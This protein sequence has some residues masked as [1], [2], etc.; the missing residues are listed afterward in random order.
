MH[1]EFV[2]LESMRTSNNVDAQDDYGL[3]MNGLE[4]MRVQVET[5]PVAPELGERIEIVDRD[6]LPMVN[7]LNLREWVIT[8][9]GLEGAADELVSMKIELLKKEKTEIRKMARD[10]IHCFMLEA[11]RAKGILNIKTMGDIKKYWMEQ[12]T[13]EKGIETMK[14]VLYGYYDTKKKWDELLEKKILELKKKKYRDVEGQRPPKGCIARVISEE[15]SEK[16]KQIQRPCLKEIRLGIKRENGLP[17]NVKKKRRKKETVYVSINNSTITNVASNN[18]IVSGM[19]TVDSTLI[20]RLRSAAS[21]AQGISQSD[22][23]IL[24]ASLIPTATGV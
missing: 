24:L 5:M 2:G 9:Y 11:F 7:E 15:K 18:N 4:S 13:T 17:R 19:N 16:V 6:Y 21:T 10:Y 20:D 8:K 1:H 14:Y 22:L 23:Q 12:K 3:D